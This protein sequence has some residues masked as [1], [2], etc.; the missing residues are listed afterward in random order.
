M[1][2]IFRLVNLHILVAI[3]KDYSSNNCLRPSMTFSKCHCKFNSRYSGVKTETLVT[4]TKTKES[5][6]NKRLL[7]AKPSTCW[8]SQTH[9]LWVLRLAG[10][11]PL[12]VFWFHLIFIFSPPLLSDSKRWISK[13]TFLQH[14]GGSYLTFPA[15]WKIQHPGYQS[16]PS[17]DVMSSNKGGR[18]LRMRAGNWFWTAVL[19]NQY[20]RSNGPAA[21][22]IFDGAPSLCTTQQSDLI[23]GWVCVRVCL[24][25]RVCARTM[26]ERGGSLCNEGEARRMSG[27]ANC[28]MTALQ[29]WGERS[30]KGEW[31]R[32]GDKAS[33]QSGRWL[34]LTAPPQPTHPHHP[35]PTLPPSLPR[36]PWGGAANRRKRSETLLQTG[37]TAAL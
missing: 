11:G 30:N 34:V 5:R 13:C 20:N 19:Y 31:Q 27:A 16:P 18:M 24:R 9:C 23:P 6:R 25:V 36:R 26:G 29:T 32:C 22:H 15:S 2:H 17:Q 10:A 8:S 12:N 21:Q 33:R 4:N 28:G 37:N 3:N 1:S 7:P 35:R 14:M